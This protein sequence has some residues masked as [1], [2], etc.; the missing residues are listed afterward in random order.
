MELGIG[1][2]WFE[3]KKDLDA[4]LTKFAFPERAPSRNVLSLHKQRLLV[5]LLL[6][7]ARK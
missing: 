4:P 5:R 3:L 7:S 2:K 1:K 6:P